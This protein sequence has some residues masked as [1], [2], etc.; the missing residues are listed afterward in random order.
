MVDKKQMGAW[1]Q[2][3]GLERVE[4]YAKR[5]R[6]LARVDAAMLKQQWIELFK[7]WAQEP[8]DAELRDRFEDIEAELQLRGD[9]PPVDAVKAEMDGLTKL[10]KDAFDRL[11]LDPERLKEMSLE[12]AEDYRRFAG[13]LA[14]AKKTRH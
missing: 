14:A 1:L 5:G 13:T 6:K 3:K 10:V 7:L 4:E 12:I 11:S 9:T 8:T 2:N